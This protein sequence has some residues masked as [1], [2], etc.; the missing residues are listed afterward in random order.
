MRAPPGPNSF[1]FMQFLRNLAKSYV[2]ALGSWRPLIREILDMPLA[3]Q[4]E[5]DQL[6]YILAGAEYVLHTR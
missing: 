6:V 1:N 4:V 2:A 3:K 5:G